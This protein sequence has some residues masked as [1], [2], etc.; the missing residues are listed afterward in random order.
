MP[1]VIQGPSCVIHPLPSAGGGR[2][3]AGIHCSCCR[4][5]GVR[6]SPPLPRDAVTATATAASCAAHAGRC[7]CPAGSTCAHSEQLQVSA[8]WRSSHENRLEESLLLSV[9]AESVSVL[10]LRHCSVLH[11]VASWLCF[12]PWLFLCCLAAPLKLQEKPLLL[13]SPSSQRY[14]QCEW[15][16]TPLVSDTNQTPS[17]SRRVSGRQSRL[18]LSPFLSPLAASPCRLC[19]CFTSALW[20]QVAGGRS[21]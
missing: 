12:C 8:L 11:C 18:S 15:R 21:P 19:V 5:A 17:L 4:P 20:P 7:G 6:L 3:A 10:L 13:P 9:M 14:S 2:A 16:C 1:C